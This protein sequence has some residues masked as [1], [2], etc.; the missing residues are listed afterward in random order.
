LAD[1]VLFK[2]ASKMAPSADRAVVNQERIEGH[3]L[4]RSNGGVIQ[5]PRRRPFEVESLARAGE[6]RLGIALLPVL[7]YL[8]AEASGLVLRMVQTCAGGAIGMEA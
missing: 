8:G 1:L 3:S 7:S 2:R 5:T 4:I 6:V